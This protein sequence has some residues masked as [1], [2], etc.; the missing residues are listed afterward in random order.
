MRQVMLEVNKKKVVEKV[1]GSDWVML[2]RYEYPLV[3]STRP[4]ALD[5]KGKHHTVLPKDSLYCL[6]KSTLRPLASPSGTVRHRVV[7][8]WEGCGELRLG[9]G[10]LRSRWRLFPRAIWQRASL[11]A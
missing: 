8:V 6:V 4:S 10:P 9:G 7:L 1:D 5:P 3:F 11:D 2:F